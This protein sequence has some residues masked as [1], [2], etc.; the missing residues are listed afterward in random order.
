MYKYRNRNTGDVAEFATPSARLENLPNWDRIG[1]PADSAEEVVEP[2]APAEEVDSFKGGPVPDAERGGLTVE[3]VADPEV[4]PVEPV[5]VAPPLRNASKDEWVD[6]AVAMGANEDE[7][8]KMK[9]DELIDMF[10]PNT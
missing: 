6:F 10:G 9:R 8:K 4:E 5:A 3:P 7:A 2:V 1:V